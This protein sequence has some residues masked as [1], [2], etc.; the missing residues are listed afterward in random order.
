MTMNGI[1]LRAGELRPFLCAHLVGSRYLT[2]PNLIRSPRGK[3]CASQHSSTRSPVF[4]AD[5]ALR[6]LPGASSPHRLGMKVEPERPPSHQTAVRASGRSLHRPWRGQAEPLAR[7][8]TISSRT[9]VGGG[10]S[11]PACGS[12]FVPLPDSSV[13][14]PLPFN[15]RHASPL[16]PHSHL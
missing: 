2:F 1:V 7:M 15:C 8:R 10:G 6:W 14:S 3:S 11:R 5:T 9:C 12:L 13:L 4:P 16:P